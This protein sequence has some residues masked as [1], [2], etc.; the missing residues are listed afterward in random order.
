MTNVFETKKHVKLHLLKK[1][2]NIN[3]ACIL[4]HC[5]FRACIFGGWNSAGL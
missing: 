2:K 1:K 4:R 5:I 3:S